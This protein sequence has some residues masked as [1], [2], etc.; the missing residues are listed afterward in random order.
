MIKKKVTRFRFY[1][2]PVFCRDFAK[3]IAVLNTLYHLLT[4]VWRNLRGVIFGHKF[5]TQYIHMREK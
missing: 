5:F 4:F 1:V 2:D 3:R